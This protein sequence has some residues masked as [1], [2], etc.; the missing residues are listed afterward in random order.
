VVGTQPP[1]VSYAEYTAYFHL[2]FLLEPQIE[3]S[4]FIGAG[5]AVGPRAF[6]MHDQDMQIDVIDIDPKILELTRT[7]FY[8]QD[9]PKI[10]T[11]ARDGRIFVRDTTV[12]YDCI[13]LDAFTIG[14]RIPFHLVT[15]EFFTLCSDRMSDDGVFVMNI[16]SA[17]E[18]K[19]AEI[20]RSTYRTLRE[21]FPQMY[22]FRNGE[23]Q[24][25]SPTES[26]NI[27]F[28]AAKAKGQV[29]ASDWR[30]R[31]EMF[32]SQ[33]YVDG[34]AVQQLVRNL[35]VELPDVSTAPLFTDDYAPIE[36]MSF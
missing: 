25:V 32:R 34:R 17:L 26:T 4:L 23:A 24:G 8:L 2:A 28:V 27:I 22:V 13:L 18:G 30:S 19:D 15:R 31:A 14:G 33:S 1:H 12:P 3:R 10:S 6:R 29:S 7:H 20:F 21:V 5:G 36:T 11:I 35:V 9:D 16:N